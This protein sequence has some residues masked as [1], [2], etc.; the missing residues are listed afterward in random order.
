MII[1]LKRLLRPGDPL[2]F[3]LLYVVSWICLVITVS[4]MFSRS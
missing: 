3:V 2:L 4:T 1:W